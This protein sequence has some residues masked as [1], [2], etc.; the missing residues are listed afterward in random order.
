MCRSHTLNKWMITCCSLVTRRPVSNIVRQLWTS[1]IHNLYPDTKSFFCFQ[2]SSL[3]R[4]GWALKIHYDR[5][6]HWA[7]DNDTCNLGLRLRH[8]NQS[9]TCRWLHIL[10]K[11][12]ESVCRSKQTDRN[13]YENRF[14][15]TNTSVLVSRYQCQWLFVKCQLPAR[16]QPAALGNL[17]IHYWHQDLADQ[18]GRGSD[19]SWRR[20]I[21]RG[22]KEIQTLYKL[23][24]ILCHVTFFLVQ[25]IC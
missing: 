17:P 8:I 9:Q 11:I 5:D 10:T 6:T 7:G 1:L 15:Y 13:K 25:C 21:H 19:K 14:M 22:V 20:P 18:Q 3:Q 16:F 12:F 24:L 23:F 4:A 2:V